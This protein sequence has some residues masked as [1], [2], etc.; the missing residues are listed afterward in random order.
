MPRRYDRGYR[1]PRG[2]IEC[3]SAGA[4]AFSHTACS[5][6]RVGFDLVRRGCD[7]PVGTD[8]RSATPW[9]GDHLAAPGGHHMHMVIANGR[10][11]V[12]GISYIDGKRGARW[13]IQRGR[14]RPRISVPVAHLAPYPN[15]L[16]AAVYDR[17][18][19]SRLALAPVPWGGRGSRSNMR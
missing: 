2:T 7:W 6:H 17:D 1:R 4:T 8:G 12:F 9:V 14:A 10:G 3:G 11:G 18:S 5:S 15:P 16:V 13:V 19:K